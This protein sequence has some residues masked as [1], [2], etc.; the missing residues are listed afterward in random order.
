MK[1]APLE[2]V[3]RRLK[4]ERDEAD[5]RY[6]EALTELERRRL[7]EAFEAVRKLQDATALRFDAGGIA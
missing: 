4:Q 5:R 3:L 7:A 6:N 1:D 2:Q